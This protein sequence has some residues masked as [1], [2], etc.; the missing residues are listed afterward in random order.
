MCNAG[1]TSKGH[2]QPRPVADAVGIVRKRYMQPTA[3]HV[4]ALTGNF[5]DGEFDPPPS[6]PAIT[7]RD[8]AVAGD[9]YFNESRQRWMPIPSSGSKRLSQIRRSITINGEEIAYTLQRSTRRRR[10]IQLQ[11]DPDT[12]FKLLVPHTMSEREIEE[13]LLKRS[14]WILK[15]RVNSTDESLDHD[16]G[17][18]GTTLLRGRSVDLVVR[19]RDLGDPGRELPPT[20]AKSLEGDTVTVILPPCLDQELKSKTVRDWLFK[21]YRQE[22]WD[23][24]RTRVAEFGRV[25]GVQ[26]RQLKLSN[27]KKRWG[28]CSGKRSINLNWRLITLDDRLIDYVIV[29]ELA[30]LVELNHSADF[31]RVVEGVFPDHRELRRRLRE[32]NPSVLG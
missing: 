32:Q 3:T 1:S 16:W 9:S 30:H 26:P 21:W 31:W 20:V 25:M 18:A 28:S 2:R 19:E 13:F 27:A 5:L 14:E 7:A 22:A 29:H 6:P 17:S 12:G 10:T 23:H 11:A 15:Q 4:E 8:A 24:L